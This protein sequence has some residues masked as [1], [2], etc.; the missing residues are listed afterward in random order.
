MDGFG[1]SWGLLGIVVGAS[2]KLF[3]PSWGPLVLARLG[4]P[5]GVSGA[6]LGSSWGPLGGLL[7]TLV[8]HSG[9]SSEVLGASWKPLGHLL[10]RF[11]NLMELPGEP[12]PT[13]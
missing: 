5:L 2:R 1:A 6:S 4:G 3:G 8:T 12:E 11:G 10:T 9:P 7:G 13:K